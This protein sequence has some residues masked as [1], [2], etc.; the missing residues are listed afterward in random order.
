MAQNSLRRG[1]NFTGAECQTWSV[2]SA[3]LAV[4]LFLFSGQDYTPEGQNTLVPDVSSHTD[5]TVTQ[6]GNHA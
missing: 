5:V 2:T 3:I 6:A 4:Q 1:H